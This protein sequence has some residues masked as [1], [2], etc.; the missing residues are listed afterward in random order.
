MRRV[1]LSTVVI[2]VLTIAAAVALIVALAG[3]S[4]AAALAKPKPTVRTY[5]VT[6]TTTLAPFN[7]RKRADLWVVHRLSECRIAREGG[8]VP[9]EVTLTLERRVKHRLRRD[10]WDQVG[11][12]RF[13]VR[14]GGQ[15]VWPDLA[16]GR[17]RETVTR[18]DAEGGAIGGKDKFYHSGGRP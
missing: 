4:K 10:T 1:P 12:P 15:V 17:Y 14:C 6:T 16:K 5:S 8:G 18:E 9:V 7:T 3:P 11:N 13:D 2:S